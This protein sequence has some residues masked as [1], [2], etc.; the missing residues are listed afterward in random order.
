[1]NMHKYVKEWSVAGIKPLNGGLECAWLIPSC[2]SD[3]DF[4]HRLTEG[5][6]THSASHSLLIFIEADSQIFN[7]DGH[8]SANGLTRADTSWH[9]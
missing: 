9:S 2:I 1:M 5:K 6:A 3:G 4:S 8:L 7:S